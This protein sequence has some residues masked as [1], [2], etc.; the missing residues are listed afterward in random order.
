L[1]KA[2]VIFRALT[3]FSPMLA[4]TCGPVARV[5]A[6]AKTPPILLGSLE[7]R[8]APSLLAALEQAQCDDATAP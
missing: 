4:T 1:W 6:S 3:A 5:A 7:H 2:V 8:N